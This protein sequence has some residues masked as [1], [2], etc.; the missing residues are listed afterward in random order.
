MTLSIEDIIKET[1][2]MTP[3]QFEAYTE[4]NDIFT[5]WDEV[6]VSDFNHGVY[7]VALPD[8]DKAVYSLNGAAINFTSI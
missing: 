4:Q 6:C 1:K 5:E 2:G 8:Y 7:S 3:K